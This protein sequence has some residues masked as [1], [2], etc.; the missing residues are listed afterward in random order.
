MLG[1]NNNSP[2]FGCLARVVSTGKLPPS[3]VRQFQL[4]KIKSEAGE[5][6]HIV[7]PPSASPFPESWGDGMEMCKHRPNRVNGAAQLIGRV[8]HWHERE[9]DDCGEYDDGDG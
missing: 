6:F 2:T 7:H 5:L 4:K 1:R 9:V 3:Q 8:P